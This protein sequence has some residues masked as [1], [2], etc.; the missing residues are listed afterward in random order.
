M[1]WTKTQKNGYDIY[2]E[3]NLVIDDNESAAA[4]NVVYTSAL[5]DGINWEDKKF[6]VT[7]DMT[8]V[9]GAAVVM[10]AIWQTSVT[11][12]TSDDVTGPSSASPSWVDSVALNM[13]IGSATLTNYSIECDCTDIYAPYARLA[14]VTAATDLTDD[15]GRCSV[16]IAHKPEAPVNVGLTGTDIGGDGTLG[17]GPD[18]S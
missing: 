16:I 14:I 7:V 6:A 5:P 17:I 1:A 15:A 12:V 8:T 9:A 4:E 10:D 13:N 18:P 2:T 3:A 11:G